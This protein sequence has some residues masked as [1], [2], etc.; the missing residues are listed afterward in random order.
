[1]PLPED[2]ES[3]EV[4]HLF[5]GAPDE[6]ARAGFPGKPAEGLLS[7]KDLVVEQAPKVV[8]GR[9]LAHVRSRGK[10][11][12]VAGRPGQGGVL[13]YGRTAGQRLRELVSLRL[14]DSTVVAGGAELVGF[15]KDYEVV[16]RRAGISQRAK[17]GLPPD[18]V[19]RDDREVAPWPRERVPRP[20]V[21]T[22]YDAES[23]PEQSAQFP[24]P[25][26]HQPRRGDNENAANPP[27]HQHLAHVETGHDGLAGPGIV[28]EEETKRLLGEHVLVHRDPLVGERMYPG[29]LAREGRV[30]LVAVSQ[31]QAFGEE[32]KAVGVTAEVEDGRGQDG[33]G[34]VG[35]GLRWM[36]LL[37]LA[38]GGPTRVGR[39]HLL[40]SRDRQPPGTR[41]ACLPPMDRD[42]GDSDTFAELR[43]SEIQVTAEAADA[44]R[45]IE[46]A[47][48]IGAPRGNG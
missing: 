7:A 21:G 40:Q 47:F 13:R 18:R 28:G 19:Q 12:Q 1:M 11:Q 43:L 31:P 26:P 24:L 34:G 39:L 44:S 2:R 5:L 35:E 6:M 42:D 10:Q 3:L 8:V 37:R 22:R 4:H 29:D 14:P 36:P 16:G 30:E 27:A 38:P 17:G 41:L 46:T 23:E 25:V 45:Q 48:G 9:V 20:G 32:G 33:I 15:V